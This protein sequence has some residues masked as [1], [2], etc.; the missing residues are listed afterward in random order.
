MEFLD[1][2]RPAWKSKDTNKVLN[3]VKKLTNNKK[4]KYV[5]K[6]NIWRMY[7]DRKWIVAAAMH[8]ITDQTFLAEIVN[9]KYDTTI[10]NSYCDII[11]WANIA[12]ITDED[13]FYKMLTDFSIYPKLYMSQ[14]TEI[15]NKLNNNSLF[16]VLQEFS[17]WWLGDGNAHH[18]IARLVSQK[19]G[20]RQREL[21]E[22]CCLSDN[23]VDDRKKAFNEIKEEEEE[24]FYN[25]VIIASLRYNYNGCDRNYNR[26]FH[27]IAELAFLALEKI[28]EQKLLAEIVCT[29]WISNSDKEA[30]NFFDRIVI[31]FRKITDED[32]L[33]HIAKEGREIFGVDAVAGI[34]DRNKLI[35]LSNYIITH[36]Y[37]RPGNVEGTYAEHVTK[38][39]DAVAKAASYRLKELGY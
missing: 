15:V 30:Q 24:I 38:T 11:R 19:L 6:N 12:N 4:L 37:S 3:A 20:D 39:Y 23:T 7:D 29:P 31:A 1:L 36:S 21:F 9:G 34:T 17:P 10:Y 22:I 14:I 33:F 25:I 16:R 28:E 35:E 32:L 18:H 2:F 13:I 27:S 8:N 5:V 26:S